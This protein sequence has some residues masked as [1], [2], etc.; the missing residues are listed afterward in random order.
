MGLAKVENLYEIL[1]VPRKATTDLLELAY[2]DKM[3]FWSSMSG[4]EAKEQ[5]VLL[6]KAFF[7]LSHAEKRKE[8]D[9]SLDFEFVL[10]DAK[11]KDPEMAYLY[12][13]YRNHLNKPYQELLGEFESF[14]REL[15]K[16][17]QK[18]KRTTFYMVGCLVVYSFLVIS[19]SIL[20]EMEPKAQLLWEPFQ[21]YGSPLFLVGSCLG[22]L[23][24][25]KK[26]LLQDRL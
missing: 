10:I 2:Q 5:M 15:G 4:T 12:E 22:Y 14:R 23:W 21:I 20:G 6:S 13:S 24:F 25:R 1:G 16:T 9:N 17:L 26:W 3:Q 7:T 11:T 8:Y 18:L 19:L